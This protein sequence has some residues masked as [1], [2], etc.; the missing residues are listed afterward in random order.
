[1]RFLS[2]YISRQP[3]RYARDY[4]D[5]LTMLNNMSRTD[6]ADIG[7]KPGDFS[8]IAHEIASR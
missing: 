2:R 3:S 7:I 1:M 4:R 5:A 6:C 8:R